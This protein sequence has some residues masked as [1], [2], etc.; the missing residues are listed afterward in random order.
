VRATV[1]F[2]CIRIVQAN[3]N[4]LNLD[5][6]ALFFLFIVDLRL[7]LKLVISLQVHNLIQKFQ[8]QPDKSLCLLQ[9]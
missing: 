1:P 5:N 4:T 6:L 3:A 9:Y 2:F 8:Q 7:F